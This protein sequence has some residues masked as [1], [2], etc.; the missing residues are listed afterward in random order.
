M[1]QCSQSAK[2]FITRQQHWFFYQHQT[3]YYNRRPVFS[4][5]I[6]RLISSCTESTTKLVIYRKIN[7]LQSHWNISSLVSVAS[8]F[9]RRMGLSPCGRTNG[10]DEAAAGSSLCPS[11]SASP[12]WI[13]SGWRRYVQSSW[14]SDSEMTLLVSPAGCFHHKTSW[15]LQ[16]GRKSKNAINRT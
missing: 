12:T 5:F 2:N 4:Q 15:D 1:V 6:Y 7:K 8:L 3:T 10:T 9:G 14:V 13:V 11:S 16:H